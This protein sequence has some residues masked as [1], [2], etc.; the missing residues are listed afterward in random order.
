MTVD[1]GIQNAITTGSIGD[2]VWADTNGNGLQDVGENG[3]PRR[4]CYLV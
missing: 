1:A 3:V 2:F 4:N